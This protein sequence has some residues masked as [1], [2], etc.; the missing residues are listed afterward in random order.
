MLTEIFV[1]TQ[2][3]DG[4]SASKHIGPGCLGVCSGKRDDVPRNHFSWGVLLPC[5][6]FAPILDLPH[7]RPVQEYSTPGPTESAN[8]EVLFPVGFAIVTNKSLSFMVLHRDSPTVSPSLCSLF[9]TF[10]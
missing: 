6:V 3:L 8:C 2:A 10:F 5:G 9:V 7:Q 1:R 4:A